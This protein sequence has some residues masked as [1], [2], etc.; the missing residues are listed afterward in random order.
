MATV[1]CIDIIRWR[2]VGTTICRRRWGKG[3]GANNV[4]F[5]YVAA[6]ELLGSQQITSVWK[7]KS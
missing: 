2:A 6:K 3:K 1:G 4:F 5:R 7:V